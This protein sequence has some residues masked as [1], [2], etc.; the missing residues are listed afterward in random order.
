MSGAHAWRRHWS[1]KFCVGSV[2]ELSYFKWLQI[3]LEEFV[4]FSVSCEVAV[5]FFKVVVKFIKNTTIGNWLPT[6]LSGSLKKGDG[7]K[8]E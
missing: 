3:Q 1:G 4:G 2:P 8:L 6:L 7:P 5:K